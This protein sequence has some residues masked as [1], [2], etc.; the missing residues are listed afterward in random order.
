MKV[1]IQPVIKIDGHWVKIFY[2][3][4]L[5]DY[6]GKYGQ[7]RFAECEIAI[8]RS[9]SDSFK[10]QAI[11][12]EL[13][14]FIDNTYNNYRLEEAETDALATGIHTLLVDMGVEFDWSDIK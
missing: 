7:S 6:H 14:H 10:M 4:N 9:I 3:D 11:I 5:S 13:L 1:K 8:D 2:E 12:H